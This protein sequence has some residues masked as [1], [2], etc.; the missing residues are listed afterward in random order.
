LVCS[1]VDACAGFGRAWTTGVWRSGVAACRALGSGTFTLRP[2]VIGGRTPL[3]RDNSVRADGWLTMVGF[4]PTFERPLSGG[5]WRFSDLFG[6]S[7]RGSSGLFC[8][9]GVSRV[10]VRPLAG[11]ACSILPWC[12]GWPT[13]PFGSGAARLMDAGD[14]SPRP[15]FGWENV[16][17][18]PF[19]CGAGF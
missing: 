11:G 3:R 13:A 14:F 10:P 15:E 7:P 18:F 2:S 5:G 4:A 8:G 16:R 9:R 6:F 19:D 1:P 12:S 17:Q